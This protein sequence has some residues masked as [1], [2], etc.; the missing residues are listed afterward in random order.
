MPCSGAL[1]DGCDGLFIKSTCCFPRVAPPGH[2]TSEEVRGGGIH[3]KKKFWLQAA[4]DA[5]S[6]RPWGM[7]CLVLVPLEFLAWGACVGCWG[8]G[9]VEMAVLILSPVRCFPAGPRGRVTAG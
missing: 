1:Q 4:P 2:T 9:L 7:S 5:S 8:Q 3:E 6:E